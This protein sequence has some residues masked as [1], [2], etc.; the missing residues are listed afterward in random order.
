MKQIDV[1][2]YDIMNDTRLGDDVKKELVDKLRK[3]YI[4][5]KKSGRRSAIGFG[6]Q[7]ERKINSKIYGSNA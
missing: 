2:L 3:A 5:G 7:L 1:I 6:R 4:L